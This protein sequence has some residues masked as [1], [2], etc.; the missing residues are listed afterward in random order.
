MTFKPWMKC[1]AL[2]LLAACAAVYIRLYPL[3]AHIW[4]PTQEKATMMVILNLKKELLVK[5]RTQHPEMPLDQANRLASE[6]LNHVLR[7]DNARVRRAIEQVNHSLHGPEGPK[8][9]PVYLLEADPFYFYNLTENIVENGRIAQVVK[10]NKYFNPLMG[11]PFGFW[12]PLSLHPYV[13]FLLYQAAKIFDPQVPLMSAVAFTPLLITV[14]ALAAFLWCGRL[15]GLGWPALAAAVFYLSMAPVVLKRSSLGWYDTDPYNLLFP[16]IFLGIW[17]KSLDLSPLNLKKTG[18]WAAAALALVLIAYSLI[19]QG[20][21]FLF[22]MTLIFAAIVGGAG[23]FLQ[24]NKALGVSQI[25][26]AGA[27]LAASAALG[28]LIYGLDFF[29]FFG[30]GAAELGKFTVK[31]LH[32]WPNLFIEV[33]E[34]K[35]TSPGEL[36]AETGGPVVWAAA[37]AGLAFCLRSF[38]KD[39]QA[40]SSLKPVLAAALLLITV[41]MTTKAGR[42]SLFTLLP[43]C[44]FFG[45]GV[46]GLLKTTSSF[47]KKWDSPLVRFLVPSVLL[48]ALLA[49]GWAGANRSIRTVLTPIFNSAWEESLQALRRTPADSIVN[50]W[51]PPGHFI[52]AIG[53][54]RVLFDGASLGKGDIG[55]WMANV[56]LNTDEAQARG[57]VRMLNLSGNSAAEFLGQR[58]MKTS[59]AVALLK[60]IASLPRPQAREIVKPFLGNADADHLL[61]LTHGN[62]VPHSYLLVYN[63]IVDGNLGLAFVGRRDFEKIET[64]NAEPALLSAV[65]RPDSKEFIDF[66]WSVSGGV[67]PRYSEPLSLVAQEGDT[68]A[69]QDGVNVRADKSLALVN[70]PRYGQGIPAGIMY[71][72]Q[73]RIVQREFPQ[74]T[75]NYMIVLYEQ[76]GV[77]TC[78]LMDK[79]LA[80]SLIMKLF[81]FDGAGLQH[82]KLFT[83]SHDLTNRTQIKIFQVD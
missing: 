74:A 47:L 55:Y 70:S 45:A 28:M 8:S 59:Q 9:D 48:V 41:V 31:G 56:F 23:F 27:F 24:K 78:R 80:Q 69:F 61:S 12:Q 16:S 64:I 39:W 83:S 75:L 68:L 11:A 18:L 53:Q 19:W 52:K 35:K 6:K 66:L 25:T 17:F 81:F 4:S 14:L 62:G 36:M 26:G 3:Q 38:W 72:G 2:W 79:N 37:A 60:I 50:T 65:P 57:L 1:A 10:G 13:G 22:F 58:G 33:G 71:A 46:D 15:F 30:E 51:W 77:P 82:F 63:E 7:T 40:P 21:V 67:P 49:W 20:W 76:D 29:S 43:L 73:G 32:L 54:R 5:I 42:F 44:L 34:L